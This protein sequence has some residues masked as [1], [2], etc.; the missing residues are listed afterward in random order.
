MTRDILSK[1]PSTAR[2]IFEWLDESKQGSLTLRDVRRSIPGFCFPHSLSALYYFDERHDGSFD[3]AEI[4]KLLKYCNK[5]KRRVK[6]QLQKDPEKVSMLRKAI[7]EGV[8]SGDNNLCATEVRKINACNKFRCVYKTKKSSK[9]NNESSIV[10]GRPV[11]P[12]VEMPPRSDSNSPVGNATLRRSDSLA[13][14]TNAAIEVVAAAISSGASEI[15]K[16]L[17]RTE[18]STKSL[19]T[20]ESRAQSVS[21]FGSQREFSF[22]SSGEFWT[23]DMKEELA[24]DSSSNGSS[25]NPLQSAPIV[26]CLG[27]EL[28]TAAVN[29]ALAERMI[30]D[31]IANLANQ[32]HDSVHRDKYMEWLWKLTNCDKKDAISVEELHLLLDALE[33]DG[34]NVKELIFSDAGDLKEPIG[35]RIMNEYNTAHTGFLSREE[36]MVLADLVVREYE[37]W[38]NRHVEVVR[39]YE[40]SHVLGYGSQG[41]VRCATKMSTG[42]RFAVKLVKRGKCSDLSRLD[43]EIHVMTMLDHPNIVRLEEVI[44]SENILYLVMELCDGGSLFSKRSSLS[45]YVEPLNESAARFYLRQLFEGLGYCHERGVAHRDLR[46][47]NLMLDNDGNLK[48]TD[49]G[50]AGVFKKG[51]DLFSTTLVGSLYHLSPEQIKGICYSGE[52]V[53]MWSSGVVAHCLL[54]GHPPFRATDVSEL[55][56]DITQG[57]YEIPNHLSPEAQ[58]LIRSLLQLDPEKRPNC[59]DVLSMRWFHVGPEQRLI[60]G[61]FEIR[62]LDSWKQ[63]SSADIEKRVVKLLEKLDVHQHRADLAFNRSLRRGQEWTLKCY[64][65]HD[66]LKFYASFFRKPPVSPVSSSA[67]SET[68]DMES[69]ALMK[70]L[71]LDGYSAEVEDCEMSTQEESILSHVANLSETGHRQTAVEEGAIENA[72]SHLEKHF[73]P[74][75]EFRHQDGSCKRFSEIVHVLEKIMTE[76]SSKLYFLVVASMERNEQGT[77]EQETL[78]SS[79]SSLI[80]LNVYDLVHPVYTERFQEWNNYLIYLGL[81]LFHSGVEVFNKEYSFGASD[82]Y[83]TGVFCVTPRHTIGAIYRQSVTIGETSLTAF[84]VANVLEDIARDYPGCS[85]SLLYNNCNHFSNDLCIRL[86]GHPIPKWINRLAFLAGYFPCISTG[87]EADEPPSSLNDTGWI[88]SSDR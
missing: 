88:L 22:E 55:L 75:L 72:M 5:Q 61:V 63:L 10:S 79:S 60:L 2:K 47:D 8:L 51:W 17:C 69:A 74:L 32:L 26:S 9:E 28:S 24:K 14:E 6:K 13:S 29:A 7:D 15:N 33:E 16:E 40:L 53:D 25:S 4:V 77:L 62:L 3:F 78:L 36:F 67:N 80:V 37:N 83:E 43:R 11:I 84:E 71:C 59:R 46:L 86:C 49:F 64:F 82:S 21:M 73:E 38:Q 41:V 48:I 42:D 18:D 12:P 65:P 68:N 66:G 81:G 23:S 31:C 54:V 57:N 76:E 19:N 58:E 1:T 70:E 27:E 52:K 39:D 30:Q 35:Q 87:L 50:H 20:P 44:E 85:Y 45:G 34:I 56:N